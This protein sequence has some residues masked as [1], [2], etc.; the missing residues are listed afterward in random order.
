MIKKEKKANKEEMSRVFEFH[1]NPLKDKG[2]GVVFNT[3]CS[4]QRKRELYMIGEAD[5]HEFLEEVSEIFKSFDFEKA[6]TEANDLL[7]RNFSSHL[8][9]CS[10]CLYPNLE[11]NVSKIG[12]IKILLLRD[13]EVFDMTSEMTESNLFPNVLE[14]RLKKHD[15]VLI[16][17]NNVF[18]AFK[19]QNIL[20]ELATIKKPKQVKQLFKEKKQL[21]KEFSGA[22][23]LS[24]CKKRIVFKKRQKA[25]YKGLEKGIISVLIFIILLLLGYIFFK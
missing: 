25:P 5:K 7:Q 24:F 12:N 8:S 17:T 14:G 10:F 6:L 22:C 4:L 16:L 18:K 1:F 2:S 20:E 19:E 3:F 11:I 15:K 21:L 9:F 13:S 23:I